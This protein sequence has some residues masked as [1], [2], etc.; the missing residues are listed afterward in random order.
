LFFADHPILFYGLQGRGGHK[1]EFARKVIKGLFPADLAVM[2][3][4]EPREYSANFTDALAKTIADKLFR[5]D[6]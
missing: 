6:L 5:T 4:D 1:V 2:R 3:L